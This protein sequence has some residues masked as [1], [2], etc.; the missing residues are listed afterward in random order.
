MLGS[1]AD[2]KHRA[3]S[4]FDFKLILQVFVLITNN[5]VSPLSLRERVRVRGRHTTGPLSAASPTP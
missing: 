2:L 5:A 1:Y 4:D 3:V